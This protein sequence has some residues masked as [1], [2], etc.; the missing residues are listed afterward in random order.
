MPRSS[1]L[2]HED[3]QAC[4]TA[5]AQRITELREARHWRQSDLARATGLSRAFILQIEEGR[6][7][8]PSARTL[9]ALARALDADPMEL[10][11]LCGAIP[12]EMRQQRVREELDL[13]MYLRRQR[14]LSE[15]F[16]RT[17]LHLIRL[18]EALEHGTG[19]TAE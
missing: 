15:E 18:A 8:E 6:A 1:L 17:L 10:L 5:F 9:G 4:A 3:R 13:T 2:N 12:A 14:R 11:E 7:V 19:E 16:T